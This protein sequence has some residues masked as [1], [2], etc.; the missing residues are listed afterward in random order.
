MEESKA[1]GEGQEVD[2]RRP[3]R[4]RPRIGD[5]VQLTIP[6][7]SFGEVIGYWSGYQFTVK[8]DGGAERGLYPHQVRRVEPVRIRRLGDV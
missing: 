8:E 7:Y 5:R 1:R 3:E 2:V 4:P 6:P